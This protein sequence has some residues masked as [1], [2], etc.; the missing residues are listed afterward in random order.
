MPLPGHEG[1]QHCH[2]LFGEVVL[3][4]NMF[5]CLEVTRDHMHRLHLFLTL[6]SQA[7]GSKRIPQDGKDVLNIKDTEMC[8]SIRADSNATYLDEAKQ[9]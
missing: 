9:N 3:P 2:T 5:Q 4:Y 1:L 6:G 8:S 7:D